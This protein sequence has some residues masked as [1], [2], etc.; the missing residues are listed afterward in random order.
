[1]TEERSP[2]GPGGFSG[3]TA[4]AR[5][6]EAPLRV[7]LRTETGSAAVLVAATV[8]ALVWINVSTSSYASVWDARLT[9]RL[10]GAAVSL[11]LR[12]WVNS[13]LMT[14]FFFVFG[15]EARR[16]F[17]M[18]E[19]RERRRLALP[20]L[21]GLGGLIVPVAIYLAINHGGAVRG[22]GAAMST[23]T[24]FALGMLAVARPTATA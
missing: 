20:V 6:L 21:A 23:D 14:F 3:R 10:A 2:A 15:L 5:S 18:G 11:D 22:W 4:W 7:F 12:E 16:E 8:A 1:L 13:G 17:D 19:L 9:V 24:A